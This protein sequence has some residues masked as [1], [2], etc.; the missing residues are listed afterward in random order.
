MRA[1]RI[2]QHTATGETPLSVDDTVLVKIATPVIQTDR[3]Q[4]EEIASTGRRGLVHEIDLV[5]RSTVPEVCRKASLC[6]RLHRD[7]AE[8][9]PYFV[10]TLVDVAADLDDRTRGEE[11]EHAIEKPAVS[12][13]VV[14][15]HEIAYCFAGE[16][17]GD[18][19]HRQIIALSAAVAGLATT[20]AYA[21]LVKVAGVSMRAGFLGATHAT[22]VTGGGFATGVSVCTFWGIVLAVVLSNLSR[23]SQQAFSISSS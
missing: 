21:A 16:E 4:H 18:L 15:T 6:R 9:L 3:G 7:S 23:T 20:E 1:E 8:H 13:G 22:P 11:L 2:G 19:D 10:Q 5:G 17:I 14:A 12:I